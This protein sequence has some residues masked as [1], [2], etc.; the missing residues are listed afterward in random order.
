MV[1]EMVII[2]TIFTY[3]SNF[4]L[5]MLLKQKEKI[6]GVEK[7][8]IIF[9]VNMTILLLNGIFLFIGKMI[10]DSGVAVLE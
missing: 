2:L 4:I 6:Q 7:L 8:S 1:M 9:G 3:G 10:S 5:F